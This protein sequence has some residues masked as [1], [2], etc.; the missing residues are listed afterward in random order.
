MVNN[1]LERI[2]IDNF[3]ESLRNIIRNIRIIGALSKM[4]ALQRGKKSMRHLK[5]TCT[6]CWILLKVIQCS[7][8]WSYENEEHY[9]FV[10]VSWEQPSRSYC[11]KTVE[12][13][14]L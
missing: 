5:D 13:S 3:L 8:C 10:M 2:W 1:K 11:K 6:T 9:H 12:C 14:E 7:V 4:S